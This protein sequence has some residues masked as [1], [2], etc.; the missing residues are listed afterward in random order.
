M[1]E[2]M[3]LEIILSLANVSHVFQRQT[4][5]LRSANSPLQGE[6]KIDFEKRPVKIKHEENIVP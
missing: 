6:K 1:Q 3:I 2:L 5:R 4:S